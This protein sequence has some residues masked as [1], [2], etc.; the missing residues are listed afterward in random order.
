MTVCIDTNVLVGMFGRT[1]PWLLIRQAVLDGRILWAL[2]N[3]I[4]LEYEE[5]FTREMSASKAM[6][7]LEFIELVDDTRGVIRHVSPDFRFKTIPA[8]A[9]DDKFADC[10]I[11]A[12]ADYI[13]TEDRHFRVLAGAGFKPQPIAPQQFIARHLAGSAAP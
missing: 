5:I 10:A 9:D 8:D 6:T 1:A 4:L 3:E 2:S 12:H 13:I 11:A 7:M